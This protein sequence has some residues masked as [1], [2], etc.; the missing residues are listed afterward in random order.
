MIGSICDTVMNTLKSLT[1]TQIVM[2]VVI[3]IVVP[4]DSKK[5]VW[6]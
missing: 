5:N 6:K 1:T 4:Y 2:I 3:A